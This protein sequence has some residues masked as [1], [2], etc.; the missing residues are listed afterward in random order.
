MPETRR[1]PQCQAKMPPDAP[2]GLCPACLLKEAM[3]SSSEFSHVQGVTTAHSPASAAP[4]PKEL[5]RHF[6]QLEILELLGQGGM[7]IVYKARQPGLD[8]LVALKIL[9]VEAGRDPAFAERF[10]REARALARLT[11]PGI[12]AVYD[13]GQSD[14]RFYLLMELVDGVNLRHLLQ[15]GRLK[16]EEALKI[17][18]QLCEALQYAHEQGVVHRDI[19][20]ENILLDRRGH[21][22]IADFGLAKLLGQKDADSALTGSRQ[23]MGTPHYMAPEQMERPLAVDH[24]ADIYSLGVVF[25]E[26]LTGELPLGRFDPPSQRVQVDVRLDEVV[27]RALAKEPG[28]RYQHASDVKTEVE[29]IASGAQPPAP[30]AGPQGVS[31]QV[32]FTR[33]TVLTLIALAGWNVALA[34]LNGGYIARAE[35][36]FRKE[37]PYEW[38]QT[39]LWASTFACLGLGSWWY[40]LLVKKP[41]AP[42][43]LQ[44]FWRV[45]QTFDDR[46][47]RAAWKPLSIWFGLWFTATVYVLWRYGF[48]ENIPFLRVMQGGLGLTPV[49]LMAMF[50]SVI[51]RGQSSAGRDT[52]TPQL[53]PRREREGPSRWLLLTSTSTWGVILCA[54]G[55]AASFLPAVTRHIYNIIE[56]GQTSGNQRW[57]AI[58]DTGLFSWEWTTITVVFLALGLLLIFTHSLPRLAA[59]R[60][61]VMT[62]AGIG[63]LVVDVWRAQSNITPVSPISTTPYI[64]FYVT[65]VLAIGLLVLG[66]IEARLA[67]LAALAASNE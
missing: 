17:V 43:T 36:Y 66:V 28:R 30:K 2:E 8:R 32:L 56:P 34:V 57:T 13:F 54:L 5:A 40:Y 61:L 55:L 50:W 44:D 39:L 45:W 4:P 51:R 67:L 29:S 25:Y 18:P 64:G 26:M 6:P 58:P 60:A 12:V 24:R 19:K 47:L 38:L 53:E 48:E 27:L 49:V 1:C 37:L 35:W 59:W 41:G 52:R 20:P 62:L 23:V 21:V 7:G 22:K 14:G 46:R 9:P 63:V 11:H 33:A 15:Q 16:P 42:R 10:A 3:K 65:G 31:D